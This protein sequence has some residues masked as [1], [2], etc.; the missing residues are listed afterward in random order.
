MLEQNLNEL[1]IFALR[2]LARRTGVKSPTSKKKE[3]LINEII[4]IVSGKKTPC[5]A[6]SKQGRPPKVFGYDFAN[7]LA[8]QSVVRGGESFSRRVLNQDVS[9]NESDDVQTIVG[10]LEIVNNNAGLLWVEKNFKNETYFIPS[11]LLKGVPVK[12]GDRVVAETSLDE[13]SKVIKKIYS[14]NDCPV[15]QLGL[16]RK[17]YWDIEHKISEKKLNFKTKEYC[18]LNLCVGENIYVYGNNNNNNTKKI[19]N[20][21]NSCEIENKIYIN[22]SI[23]EKNKIFLKE[24]NYVESFIVGLTDDSDTAKKILFLAAERAKRILENGEDV[25]LV[26]DDLNSV[27]GVDE[28]Y[29]KTLISLTKNSDNG[30]ITILCVMPNFS[31]NQFEKLADVRLRID[32]DKIIKI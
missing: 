15:G 9:E 27:F 6:K 13:S 7:M 29:A 23:V 14:V 31:N 30:S 25:L 2:D 26:I 19:I 5:V 24:L 28:N 1:N 4:E 20:I 16:E 17:D 32:E 3:D 11:E 18:D 22:S 12:M 10:W 8:T 21:L